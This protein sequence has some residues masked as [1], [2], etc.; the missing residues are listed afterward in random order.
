M[1]RG[2]LAAAPASC[3]S[4]RMRPPRFTPLLL[5]LVCAGPA[6]GEIHKPVAME[7]NAPAPL[8]APATHLIPLQVVIL[9]GSRW[10]WAEVDRRVAKTKEI[11]AQCGVRL[12]ATLVELKSPTGSPSVLYEFDN[13][14]DPTSLRQVAQI[15]ARAKPAMFYVESFPD[16]T[17]QGGTA[18]PRR[19]S[20]GHPEADTA[21][22]PYFETPPGWQASYHVDAHELVHVLADIGHWSPPYQSPPGR[23]KGDPPD[24][25]RPIEGLMVA[26]NILRSNALAPYLC[27]RIKKHAGA[28]PL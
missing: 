15:L 11:L 13:K 26:N 21:W 9:H 19:T 6:A 17:S 2:A 24:P 8:A 10:T 3:Y 28:E 23:K 14:L 18:R 27:E 22:I 5:A 16:N 25:D 4:E 20:A 12:D 1:V 7:S